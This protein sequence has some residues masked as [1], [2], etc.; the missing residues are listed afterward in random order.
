[1]AYALL[2]HDLLTGC[3]GLIHGLFMAYSWL[4]THMRTHDLFI[5]NTHGLFMAYS[6]AKLVPIWFQIGS[7]LEP[8]WSQIGPKPIHWP[9]MAYSWSTHGL[10]MAMHTALRG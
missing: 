5:G 7:N 4:T 1:M 10:H 2:F 3:T 9:F 6:C 8:N